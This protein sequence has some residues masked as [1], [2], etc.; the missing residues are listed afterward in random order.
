[1][2]QCTDAGRWQPARSA[3]RQLLTRDLRDLPFA[4]PLAPFH[5]LA[6]RF[7]VLVRECFWQREHLVFLFVRVMIDELGC[8]LARPPKTGED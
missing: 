2:A 5:L 8:T 1:M 3:V 7:E 6:E 4:S